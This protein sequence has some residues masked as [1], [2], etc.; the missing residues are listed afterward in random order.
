[1]KRFD[2]CCVSTRRQSIVGA[3][4]ATFALGMAAVCGVSRA[5]AESAQTTGADMARAAALNRVIPAAMKQAKYPGAIVGVWQEGR[6]PYHRAFGVADT[7][8]RAPMRTDFNVRIASLTKS[9]TVQ[10]ILQLVQDG[11]VGLDDPIGKYVSGVPRGRVITLRQLAAMR[12]GLFNY[13]DELGPNLYK[14]PRR[15]WTPQELLDIAFSKPLQFQPGTQFDYSNTNT[16]LLGLVVEKASGMPLHRYIRER[17]TKPLG[18]RHTLLPT[19]AGAL[20]SPHPHGYTDQT[21]GNKVVDATNWNPSF[22]W[23]AGGMISILRSPAALF[24]NDAKGD[25]PGSHADARKL[26]PLRPDLRPGAAPPHSDQQ[27]QIE[28]NVGHQEQNH[29]PGGNLLGQQQQRRQRAEQIDHAAAQDAPQPEGLPERQAAPPELP[30]GGHRPR[31]DRG[32]F[33]HDQRL[34]P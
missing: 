4:A 10:A 30:D 16:I 18:L 17:I 8:T 12:S 19:G 29:Q 14:H 28:R 6:R 9:F 31:S 22:G 2:H 32:R 33:A 26:P 24:S 21:P 27:E 15:A 34:K 23:A 20:P 7:R 11:K 5:V 3:L 13:L 25:H 1:M